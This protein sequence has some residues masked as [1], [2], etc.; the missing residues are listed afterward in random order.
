MIFPEVRPPIEKDAA[1][2]LLRLPDYRLRQ[3]RSYGR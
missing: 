3:L 2:R 1:A